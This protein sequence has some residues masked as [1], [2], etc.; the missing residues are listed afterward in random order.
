MQFGRPLGKFQAIQ[1][2][3]A[4]MAELLASATVALEQGRSNRPR[5]FAAPAAV[6]REGVASES[7]G[8]IASASHQVHGAIGFTR[9]YRLQP[10]TRRLLSWRNECGNEAVW[11]EK[12]GALTLRNGADALWPWMI[13]VS[14]S[15]GR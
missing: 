5:S 11:F 3:I 14:P 9:E 2:H 8:E 15:S 4:G 13:A 1:H 7:A 10:L 12:L 6:D